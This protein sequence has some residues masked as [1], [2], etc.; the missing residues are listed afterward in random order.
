MNLFLKDNKFNFLVASAIAIVTTLSTSAVV[1][2][3]TIRHDRSDWNYRNLANSFP[4]VGYLS[5]RTSARSWGCSGTLIGSAFVL[6]AAHCVEDDISYRPL[7][8]GTFWLGGNP[9]SVSSTGSHGSWSASGRNHFAGYD[10]AI[11]RL[12]R[13]VGNVAPAT[14]FSGSGEDLQVG[15]YAG[16]G[17]TGNGI[18]GANQQSATKRAGQNLIRTGSAFDRYGYS[19]RLLISDFDDPRTAN[20]NDSLSQPVNLEYQLAPGDSGGGLFINGRV[21]GIN[22]FIHGLFDGRNDASYTD[23]S[24]STRVSLHN[25]WI[26]TA[27]SVLTGRSSTR[28]SSNGGFSSTS[29][30]LFANAPLAPEFDYFDESHPV[31]FIEVND[32]PAVP[33]PSTIFGLLSGG[34]LLSL[35]R[36]RQQRKQKLAAVKADA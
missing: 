3:G 29:G 18:T 24:A 6:T 36:R 30:T 9:Y 23:I 27:I 32:P 10:I 2:A 31:D 26:N 5:A 1:R 34:G 14:L 11:L 13:S 28:T 22:A 15:T 33:E 8:F 21:A 17:A 19:D 25:S 7:N 35:F 20:P 4:S 12:A 16:F